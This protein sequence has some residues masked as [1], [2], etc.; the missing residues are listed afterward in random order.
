MSIENLFLLY[1]LFP[2]EGTGE[3][4]VRMPQKFRA[5]GVSHVQ[6]TLPG[7]QEISRQHLEAKGWCAGSVRL[8]TLIDAP[9]LREEQIHITVRIFSF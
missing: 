7:C 1:V 3:A 2:E 9:K 6:K 8:L 4:S 5:R